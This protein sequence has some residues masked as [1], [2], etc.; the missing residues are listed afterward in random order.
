MQKYR[1]IRLVASIVTLALS[2]HK[3]LLYTVEKDESSISLKDVWL[4]STGNS[5]TDV[6]INGSSISNSRNV[7]F[8][9]HLYNF[10][11]SNI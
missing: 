6:S 8:E 7:F 4:L 1:W 9:N 2:Y 11:S 5:Q 10:Q 3:L